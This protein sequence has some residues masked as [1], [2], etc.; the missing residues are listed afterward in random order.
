[1]SSEGMVLSAHVGRLSHEA[2]YPTIEYSDVAHST[3]KPF[4]CR[5]SYVRFAQTSS[6]FA[7]V[8]AGAPSTASHLALEMV[9]S[10]LIHGAS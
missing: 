1:M 9:V 4:R 7:L 8:P 10:C 2:K 5:I 3:I 6:R